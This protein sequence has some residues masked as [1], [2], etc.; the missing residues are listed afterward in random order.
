MLHQRKKALVN[1]A[2]STHD[3]DVWSGRLNARSMATRRRARPRGGVRE[4]LAAA[5]ICT[6]A[7]RAISTTLSRALNVGF[8]L[9]PFFGNTNCSV[10]PG[11]CQNAGTIDNY[12]S[13]QPF[14]GEGGAY[15]RGRQGEVP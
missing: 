15:R 12:Y 7:R 13:A 5:V 3:P 9:L 6:L 4:E 8:T 1:Q 2:P 10:E 11:Q 14:E